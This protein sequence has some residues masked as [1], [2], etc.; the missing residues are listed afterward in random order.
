MFFSGFKFL[1]C[2]CNRFFAINKR[3]KYK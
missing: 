1:V 3:T 2:I